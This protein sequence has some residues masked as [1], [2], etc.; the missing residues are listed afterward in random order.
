ML[1]LH[2]VRIPPGEK[3]DRKKPK[4]AS[5]PFDGVVCRHVEK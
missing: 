5:H 4:E 1:H 2:R 3:N